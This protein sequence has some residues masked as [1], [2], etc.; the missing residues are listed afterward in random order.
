LR[1]LNRPDVL[2]GLN[3][4]PYNGAI[5]NYLAHLYF[6]S[7]TP[8]SMV[9]NLLPDFTKKITEQEYSN[10]II[11]GVE[12]HRFIDAYTDKHPVFKQSRS[13]ISTERRRFSAVLV[14]IFYD[15]FLAT[16]WEQYSSNS[17]LESTQFYYNSLLES[18]QFYY[19][20]LSQAEMPIPVR[21]EEA[22]ERMPKIDLLYNYR[23]LKGIEH[24]VNRVSQRIRFENNLHGGI[25]ELEN[26]FTDL[27]DDFDLFFCDLQEAVARYKAPSL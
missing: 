23:T 7:P 27:Q 17:L 9:G 11:Q 16:N 5:I 3:K 1:P 24:A 8:E 2:R 15:H 6:A 21:L 20:Q 12:L 25:V 14:D 19:T 10:E 18:T 13:R 4:T 22:I 26:N